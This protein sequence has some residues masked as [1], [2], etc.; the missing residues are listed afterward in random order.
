MAEA[1]FAPGMT[2]LISRWAPPSIRARALAGA[3]V[4]VPL[5]MVLG[6]PLCGWLL[7]AANPFGLPPWRFMFLLLA[8]PN[9]A[10]AFA[11]ALWLVDRPAQARWLSAREREW[12]ERELEMQEPASVEPTPSFAQLARDPWLWRCAVSWLLIMTGSYALV[13]WLPQIVRQMDVGRSEFAIATLSALPLLGLAIGLVANGRRSDRKAERLLHVAIPSALAGVAMVVAAVL[14]PGWPVLALLFVAGLGIGA[15]Q[16]VF[17]AVPGAV[18]LGGS[19]VPVG[20]IALISMFGTAGGIVGPWL[21]GVL[22]ARSGGFSLAIGVLSA[23]LIVV[24]PVIAPDR[25]GR[26][27]A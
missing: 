14:E 2:W 11:A 18:R 24:L 23:L 27:R 4:A 5:S 26:G 19:R 22:V 7:G 10:L 8:I 15:A 21:T 12:L 20:V 25:A 6:G 3:L 9:V 16:G 13:F 1:G 17:W